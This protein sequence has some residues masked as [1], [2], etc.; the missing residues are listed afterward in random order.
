V[1]PQEEGRRI[2]LL[3]HELERDYPKVPGDKVRAVVE[4]SWM[5]F[6]HARVRDFIPLLVGREARRQLRDLA[7]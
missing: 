5:Q 1:T 3:E 4:Q 7:G 6:L 2:L